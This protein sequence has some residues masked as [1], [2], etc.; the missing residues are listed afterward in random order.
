MCTEICSYYDFYHKCFAETNFFLSFWGEEVQWSESDI[1][2][3]YSR[4]NLDTTASFITMHLI[5]QF[6]AMQNYE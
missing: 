3:L 5:G 4:V 1:S 2:Y 6:E